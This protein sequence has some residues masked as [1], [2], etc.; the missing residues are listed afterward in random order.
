M[1]GWA[2][3]AGKSGAA[4]TGCI[5]GGA[6]CPAGCIAGCPVTGDVARIGVR[7]KHCSDGFIEFCAALDFV[8]SGDRN[9]DGGGLF[10]R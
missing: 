6:G 10:T 5:A 9:P 2:V 3:V 1:V 8:A 4:A 7:F